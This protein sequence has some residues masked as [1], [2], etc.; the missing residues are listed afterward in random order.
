M[1]KKR[2]CNWVDIDIWIRMTEQWGIFK[3]VIYCEAGDIGFKLW[4]FGK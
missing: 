1:Y 2:R 3:N 4:R